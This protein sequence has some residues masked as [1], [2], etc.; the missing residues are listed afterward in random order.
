MR[1]VY[2]IE[3]FLDAKAPQVS[4]AQAQ[5]LLVPQDPRSSTPAN[6]PAPSQGKECKCSSHPSV[7]IAPLACRCTPVTL[8]WSYARG[9]K[10]HDRLANSRQVN[11]LDSGSS[12]LFS[13]SKSEAVPVAVQ[14]EP[15]R[16]VRR[17]GLAASDDDVDEFSDSERDSPVADVH[18]VED[19]GTVHTQECDESG[20][21][22]RPR[23]RV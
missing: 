9:S 21:R 6:T 20:R 17:S 16:S 3:D 10:A 8:T 19:D 13:S 2:Q 5:S 15:V 11:S 23:L 4:Q 22:V 18:P 7:Q 12:T 14:H 1:S